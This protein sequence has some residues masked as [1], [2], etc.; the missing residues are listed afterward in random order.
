MHNKLRWALLASLIVLLAATTLW[1]WKFGQGERWPATVVHANGRLEMA[2]VDVAVKYGGRVVELPVREGDVLAAGAMVARQDDAELRAQMAAARAARTRAADA[3][4]RAR[5]ETDARIARQRLATLEWSETVK[6]FGDGQVSAVERDRRRLAVEGERA[7][8]DGARAAL[9]EAQA[10]IAEADAQVARLHAMLAETTVVAPVAGRVEY[11]VVEVGTVLPAG[12]RVAS[13]LNPD[14]IYFT[15]FLPGPQAGQL[16]IGAPAR[17]VLDAFPHE[18]IPARIGYI[19]GAA[20]FTPKYVETETERARLMY[21]VKLQ[22]TPETARKL[23]PRLK[24]GMTGDGYVRL[25][26]GTPWPAALAVHG[27]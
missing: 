6:L 23:A 24:A 2:R 12:G 26:P 17:I 9:G 1:W 8:V 15:I 14:D 16:A 27:E 18:A 19:A 5:A 3:A 25:D 21:R 7:G 11:R 20:Q 4:Q 13:L 10:A 22:L